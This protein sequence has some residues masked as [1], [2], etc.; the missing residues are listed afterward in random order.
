MRNVVSAE[1]LVL[2]LASLGAVATA[3]AADAPAAAASPAATP[4]SSVNTTADEDGSL[5]AP[6]YRVL[7][8]PRCRNC[9]P[10]GDAPL[11]FDTG[12]PHAMQ[13]RRGLDSLGMGCQTCHAPTPVPGAHLPPGAPGW[14][15][16]PAATPM[17]F[18]T[19]T[20]AQLCE[21]L[22]DP[23]KT[24]GRDLAAL[25]EHVSHDSL[26]LWAW[27]PGVGRTPPPLSHDDFVAAFRAWIDG[28]SPCP[29]P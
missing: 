8:S 12:T 16:P 4:A 1:V 6:V 9:H 23:S 3:R 10:A 15:L 21:Q 28:G 5:F 14:N 18:E 20:P 29:A 19:R 11:Q 2:L 22:K 13:V 7:E 26:V 25:L 17:I 24:G 27:N